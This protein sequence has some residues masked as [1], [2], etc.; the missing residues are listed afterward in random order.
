METPKILRL[1]LRMTSEGLNMTSAVPRSVSNF[2]DTTLHTRK[3]VATGSIICE[4]ALQLGCMT[5]A[6]SALAP[7]LG[8]VSKARVANLNPEKEIYGRRENLHQLSP[9]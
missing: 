1:R 3:Y 7:C 4:N 5:M 2:S 6:D 9:R 8:R